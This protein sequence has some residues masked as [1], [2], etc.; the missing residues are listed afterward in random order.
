MTILWIDQY[1]GDD[2]FDDLFSC[3]CQRRSRG[4][5][6]VWE[7][8]LVKG[9]RGRKEPADLFSQQKQDERIAV[10]PEQPGFLCALEERLKLLKTFDLKDGSDL[11]IG[12]PAFG[13]FPDQHAHEA[14]MLDH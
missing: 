10:G 4:E 8:H 9:K 3:I 6:S 1:P 13:M 12:S 11:C 2:K 5:I 14:R 7:N